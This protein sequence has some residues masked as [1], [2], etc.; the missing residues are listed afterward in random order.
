MDPDSGNLFRDLEKVPE[1]FKEAV[2]KLPGELGDD[3]KVVLG[4]AER[5]VVNRTTQA[6]RTWRGAV[7]IVT[8]GFPCQDISVASKGAGITGNLLAWAKN[9]KNRARC[10]RKARKRSRKKNG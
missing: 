5:V 9:Q 4:D 1:E 7:D 3:A 10:K 2:K 6:G 8:G